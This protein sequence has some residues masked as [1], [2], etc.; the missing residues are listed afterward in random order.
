MLRVEWINSG[1]LVL[2]DDDHQQDHPN[3]NRWIID[4]LNKKEL[5]GDELLIVSLICHSLNFDIPFKATKS[6]RSH[7]LRTVRMKIAHP[8]WTRFHRQ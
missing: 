7:L 3:I 6:V 4:F 5:E 8:G 1:F 2:G